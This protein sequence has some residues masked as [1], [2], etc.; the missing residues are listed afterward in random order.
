MIE[1]DRDRDREY[2]ARVSKEYMSYIYLSPDAYVH[3]HGHVSAGIVHD[4]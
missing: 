1:R 2:M 4:T 3:G